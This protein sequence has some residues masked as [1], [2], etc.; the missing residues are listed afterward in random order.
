MLTHGV[1]VEDPTVDEGRRWAEVEDVLGN[2]RGIVPMQK[3]DGISQELH[4]VGVPVLKF[5][6]P[7]NLRCEAWKV[8]LGLR[9]EVAIPG[10]EDQ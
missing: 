2:E 6:L 8:R 1:V 4:G 7:G 5:Y 10:S 3:K 9:E